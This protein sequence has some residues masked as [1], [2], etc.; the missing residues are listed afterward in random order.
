MSDLIVLISL[1]WGAVM[2]GFM[3]YYKERADNRTRAM[4]LLGMSIR[5]IA[6]GKAKVVL[7]ED[8]DARLVEVKDGI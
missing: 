6:E 3:F 8:G 7:D 1:I 4:L 5:L 2:T